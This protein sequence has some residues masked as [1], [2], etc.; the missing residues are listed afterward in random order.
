[1]KR[2]YDLYI[3][4]KKVAEYTDVN[5]YKRRLK[6]FIRQGRSLSNHITT[7]SADDLWKECEFE[8]AH[9]ETISGGDTEHSCD[10]SRRSSESSSDN[11]SES[12]VS[13]L[14]NNDICN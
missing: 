1:M 11:R 14:P 6:K 9:E 12:D 2:K 10:H 5:K 3:E 4:G 8:I 7:Q 13:S